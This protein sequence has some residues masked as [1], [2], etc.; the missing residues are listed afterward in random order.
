M[1]VTPSPSPGDRARSGI[2]RWVR[3]AGSGIRRAT[4]YAILAFLSASAVAPIAGAALGAPADYS[5][6][7]DQLGGVG[8]NF[9]SD[10]LVMTALR[11]GDQDEQEWRDAVAAELLTRLEAGDAGLRDEL[12]GLLHAVGA[13]ETALRAADEETQQRIAVAFEELQVLAVDSRR[14]LD[15][16]RSGLNRQVE[17]QRRDTGRV[18]AALA[19]T[20]SL[21]RSL[22]TDDPRPA[23]EHP[24]PTDISPFPGLA[25]FDIGDSPF[26]H[27]REELVRQ[28]L[29]RLDEQ[30]LGGPPLIVVGAS[31]AGKSSLLKAGLLAQVAADGLGEGSGGWPWLI[32][33]PGATPLASLRAALD[34]SPE[35]GR[36]IILIDQFEELFTQHTGPFERAAYVTELL[37]VP[38]ALVILAVRADFYPQCTELPPLAPLLG[39]GQVVVGPLGPG[40]L[41]RA[42]ADPARDAGLAVEPGLVEVLLRDYQPGALPLVAHA[43]RATWER[44]EGDA[45]TVAGYRATGGIRRAVAASA[46]G[47]Y[48]AL[49]EP[50]RQALRAQLL[51]LVTV[52]EGLA[53]RRRAALAEVDLAVL[54]PL[55][56]VRLVTAGEDTVEISHEALLDGWPRLAGWLAD[57]R[58]EILLRQRLSQATHDWQEA[59]EDPDALYRGARLASAR[60]LATDLPEAQRRFLAASSA[61]AE[62]QHLRERRTTRR[63]RRLV[64][65][66]GVALLLVVAGGLVAVDQSRQARANGRLA[67]SRQY[68]AEARNEHWSDPLSSVDKAL[69]SW[70]E[71]PTAEARNALIYAQQTRL[72]GYLGDRSGAV[73]VS[74]SGDGRLVAVGYLDGEIDLWD[75]ATLRRVGPVLRHPTGQMY[76]L[77]FS[78]DATSLASGSLDA[79]GVAVWDVATGAMR[80]RLAAYGAVAWLADSSAV[81]AARSD[82]KAPE[83]G[84]WDPDGRRTGSI[85]V[86]TPVG[87]GLAVSIDGKYLAYA[88]VDDSAVL[89]LPGGAVQTRF[90]ASAGVAFAADDTVFSA[91]AGDDDPVQARSP[92]SG[93]KPVNLTS[94]NGEHPPAGLRPF[95]VTADGTIRIGSATVGELLQLTAGGTRGPLTGLTGVPTGLAVSADAQLLAVVGAKDRPTLIRIGDPVLVHP[96]VV[97]HL[98]VGPAG[99]RLATGTSDPLIRVWDPRTGLLRSTIPVGGDDGPLGLGY[100]PDGSLAAA[101]AQGGRVLVYD[102]DQRLRRTLRIPAGLYPANLAW[103][104]DGTLLAV[105]VNPIRGPGQF[106]DDVQDRDDPDVIVWDTRTYAKA[107]DLRLPG[108]LAMQPVFTPDGKYLL[109]T[110]NHS[111]GRTAAAQDG[112][113]WRFRTPDLALAGSRVLPGEALDEITVS[114]DSATLAVT[115]GNGARLFDVDSLAPLRHVGRHT[116]A[117]T[118]VVW[119]PDGK[120]LATATDTSDGLI[121]LWDAATGREVAEVRGNSNQW[122]QIRFTPDSRSLIAGLND[123]TV[124]IWRLDPAGAIARLCAIAGPP[125]RAG[126]AQPPALCDN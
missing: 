35:P 113:I 122:G 55:V 78:P 8:S 13:V 105:V 93:W 101:F 63:L 58:E 57:A 74:V 29:G 22:R 6:A 43:L 5:A 111:Q 88:G 114:P 17:E 98:A 9:L 50:G 39:P 81:L 94:P 56:A 66:L 46:E 86:P 10:V 118:R 14:V 19:A 112:A 125:A 27:G 15:E 87:R 103:S 83:V 7:L 51:G 1:S 2:R 30:L 26:F 69:R 97:G 116:A 123:W 96:Q 4:P 3:S 41:R 62:A 65:G 70:A 49:D 71:S 33:T 77:A 115:A 64:A 54:A 72:I 60:E 102:H 47:V 107:A 20:T 120:L 75:T 53:V 80:A 106:D 121:L 119:S 124:A 52:V 18:L 117:T 48:A 82:A 34:A 44:R 32:L 95:A 104:P 91:G 31:G 61:A 40:E 126:G 24:Q 16:I 21:I 110:S 36:R 84:R 89:R 90:S 76:W 108:H 38:D 109:V 85:P 92:A 59:G 79:K 100:G 67:A 99:D 11:S 28:L 73:A 68:A 45:L 25:S 37:A 12:T 23:A 42:I